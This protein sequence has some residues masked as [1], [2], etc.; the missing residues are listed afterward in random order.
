MQSK[1]IGAPSVPQRNT[2]PVRLSANSLGPMPFLHPGNKVGRE[3]PP[4]CKEH[5]AALVFIRHWMRWVGIRSS[6]RGVQKSFGLPSNRGSLLR[7]PYVS[8]EAYQD[9]G[10]RPVSASAMQRRFFETNSAVRNFIRDSGFSAMQ[11][12]NERVELEMQILKYR[13]FASQVA[14]EDFL[15]RARQKIAAKN[16][17]TREESFERSTN[18]R[19]GSVKSPVRS[20]HATPLGP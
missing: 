6:G 5:A 12:K 8:V 18:K 4:A 7:Q 16:H 17:G 3:Q 9:E 11:S 19:P 2:G 15:M 1:C 10:P 14:A 20:I 13:R